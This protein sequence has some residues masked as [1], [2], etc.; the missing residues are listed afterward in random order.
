MKVTRGNRN[1]RNA[2]S[3]CH[4]ARSDWN[5]V[6]LSL[7]NVERRA[8]R[9]ERASRLLAPDG[10]PRYLYLW[11]QWRAGIV[12]VPRRGV[13]VGSTKIGDLEAMEQRDPHFLAL[14]ARPAQEDNSRQQSRRVW[15]F[16]LEVAA[17]H[18]SSAYA[19]DVMR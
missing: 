16:V 12:S 1:Q 11:F 18:T 17:I 8:V 2:S 6:V 14:K 5:I 10:Q 3:F 15:R 4:S 9:S 19:R 13:K 7:S